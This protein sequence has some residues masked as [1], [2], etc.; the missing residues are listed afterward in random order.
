M[1]LQVRKVSVNS[2]WGKNELN[3]PPWKQLASPAG[4]QATYSQASQKKEG[5]REPGAQDT[6]T[7]IYSLW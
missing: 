4:V 5:M 3:L 7:T 1:Q 6:V 2:L